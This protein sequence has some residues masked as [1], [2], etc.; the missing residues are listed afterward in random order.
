MT[1]ILVALLASLAAAFPAAADE[2]PSR[3]V[4]IVVPWPA[5]G[6]TDNIARVSALKMGAILKQPVVVE[7]RPGGTGVLGSQTVLQSPPDGYT[8]VFMAAS[9]HSVA[10]NLVKSLPFD[11][12]ESFTPISNSATFPYVLIVP[13]N[14]PYQSAADLIRAA[15]AAPG[16]IAYGSFGI[17]SGSHLAAELFRLAAGVEL[18][19]VPY[20]GG[21]QALA[22]VM[23]GQIPFMFD[24]LPS[25]I[26]N[27]RGGK[28]RALM[29]TSA[30]RSPA[31]PDVP[32]MPELMPGFEGVAW[33]GLG[34]PAKMPRDVAAKLND[35][36]KKVTTDPDF[37]QRMRDM[38]ADAAT[39]ASPEAFK[40]YMQREKQ[41]W[42]KVVTEAKIPMSD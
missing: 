28:V 24:S 31:V 20:K 38:G 3:P 1:R 26:G 42:G 36:M 22:D 7:N 2:F 9:L 18:L 11:T 25:P 27:I 12:I 30:A 4:R 19:H 40:D 21:S 32:A 6:A 23:G 17:G 29:V 35:A 10:P 34:G 8:L 41:R 15:K 39:S 5:G 33:V 16:K 37:M 14:S 13:A